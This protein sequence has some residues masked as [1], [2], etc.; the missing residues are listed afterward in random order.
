MARSGKSVCFLRAALLAAS[1][2]GATA[3]AAETVVRY[4]ASAE[5]RTLDPVANGLAITHEHAYLIY[6]NLFALD[7]SFRPQPQMVE[8][9]ETSPDG[10]SWTMTLRPGLRF[11]DGAPVTSTDVI[12]S[13][14]RWAARD[15][16]ARRLLALG[17]QMEVV[18]AATFR[19]K[20]PRAT[21]LL[22][23]ALAKP[24]GWALFI[25]RAADAETDP[26]KPVK[27][28]IGSGPFRFAAA[29]YKPGY[30]LVY[31][32]NPDYTPRA[33]PPDYFAGGKV[34]KIDRLEWFVMPDAA[35]AVAALQ[36][37]ELDIYESPPMDLVPLLRKRQDV[38]VEVHS[39]QGA[40]GFLRF[41]L[42]QPPFDKPEARRALALLLDQ[43]DFMQ[44]A[45][46]NDPQYWH[47]CY[48]FTACGGA[49][50][51]RETQA[52]PHKP[53]PAEA[54]ALFKQAGYDG[55]P[56]AFIAPGDNEV[57]KSFAVVAAQRM[58]EAGL[59]VDL[60]FSDF[61][62]MISRRGNRGPAS[63]GGWN[64]F[65]MWAFGNELDNPVAS[66][67][68]SADCSD[69]AYAGW[70]CDKTL[71]GLKDQW[72]WEVDPQH[73]QALIAQIQLQA[74]RLAPIV[75]LGQFF[76][77]VAFRTS[78]TG[79]LPTPVPVFWSLSKR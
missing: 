12:A 33:E 60:Q 34:A 46:G 32:R 9:V 28:I 26:M 50:E 2:F 7:S 8:R 64:I 54:K 39:K 41:N 55:S 52:W 15:T 24:T 25:M 38:T 40:L 11:H 44:V 31:T 77:P 68:L 22:L 56:I 6:D 10:T 76:A 62:T 43:A 67:V 74:S 3:A 5:P 48:S 75:P 65:P 23:D 21:P 1:C 13:I 69:G 37:N 63:Q 61:A 53:D 73:R 72:T 78:I 59:N 18:D 29:E 42:T 45:A 36:N 57:I 71:E 51:A 47:E 35:T 20:L 16:T 58:R 17:L 4:A 27:E 66:F 14:R 79:F 30:K 19:M 70:A 49:N